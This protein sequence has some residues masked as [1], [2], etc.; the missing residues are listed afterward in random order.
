MGG[1]LLLFPVSDRL[2]VPAALFELVLDPP[3]LIFIQDARS[4]RP[5]P[6]VGILAVV[7]DDITFLPPIDIPARK[8]QHRAG[9][10]RFAD[11]A[12][13]PILEPD[14][15]TAG[16]FDELAVLPAGE[17]QGPAVE[18]HGS[19]KPSSPLVRFGATFG[20]DCE[21]STGTDGHM[22]DIKIL[23]GKVVIDE[24]SV[25]HQVVEFLANGHFRFESESKFVAPG[26]MPAEFPSEEKHDGQGCKNIKSDGCEVGLE[27]A[28]IE[29][30]HGNRKNYQGDH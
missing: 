16:L 21:E 15:L 10:D 5:S 29:L 19:F 4:L 2:H 12:G 3:D 28:E 14:G 11:G 24:V 9:I 8:S 30:P 1:L 18:G 6:G 13:D 25:A 27:V 26:E 7:E 20:L 23:G 22:V 17:F